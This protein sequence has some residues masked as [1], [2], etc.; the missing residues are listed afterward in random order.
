MSSTLP[1]PIDSSGAAVRRSVDGVGLEAPNPQSGGIAASTPNLSM[2]F[3]NEIYR[4]SGGTQGIAP[5]AAQLAHAAAGG[6]QL[7]DYQWNSVKVE[8]PEK[9][10]YAKTGEEEMLWHQTGGRLGRPG[11]PNIRQTSAVDTAQKTGPYLASEDTTIAATKS[12]RQVVVNASL[13]RASSVI[14]ATSATWSD[15]DFENIKKLIQ[16]SLP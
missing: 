3:A 4:R 9:E 16:R 12:R 13:N 11:N 15:T 8:K 1:A 6:S 7:T 14:P 10:K 2:S 5:T